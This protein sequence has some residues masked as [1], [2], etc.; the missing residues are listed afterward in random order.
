MFIRIGQL[1]QWI[2]QN[3]KLLEPKVRDTNFLSQFIPGM[4]FCLPSTCSPDDIRRAISEFVGQEV[5]YVDETNETRYYSIVTYADDGWCYTRE[6][7]DAT[8]SFDGPDI[9]VM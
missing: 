2:N 4:D 9:A 8:P 6:T 3:P 1:L 5:I 7:V